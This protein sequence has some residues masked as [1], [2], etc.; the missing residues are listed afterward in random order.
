MSDP[1]EGRSGSTLLHASSKGAGYSHYHVDTK[2]YTYGDTC[3]GSGQ[4]TFLPPKK[5][6][7]WQ[8]DRMFWI[9]SDGRSIIGP[10]KRLQLWTRRRPNLWT[11]S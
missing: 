6:A 2:V 1:C 11:G 10:W 3:Y 7:G 9:N 4:A 8:A 5:T